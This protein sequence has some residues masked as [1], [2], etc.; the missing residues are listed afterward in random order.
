MEKFIDVKGGFAESVPKPLSGIEEL[1]S[2]VS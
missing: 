2:R 1:G